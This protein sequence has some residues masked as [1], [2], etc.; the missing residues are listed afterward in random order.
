MYG[1]GKVLMLNIDSTWR[2]RYE[3]GDVYH[4]R[5][6]GNILRWLI[7]TPLEGEGKYVR[8]STDKEQYRQGEVV[9]VTARVL[10]KGYYPF[11]AGPVFVEVTDP[12]ASVR[13]VPLELQDPKTGLYEGRLTAASSGSWRLQSVVPDL[14]E[15]G[16]L[17]AVKI[18]VTAEKLED[19]SLRMRAALLRDLAAITGGR[20]HML[21]TADAI[22]DEIKRLHATSS[23]TDRKG[24]WDTL[25]VILL[26]AAFI[27]V[28]WLLRKRKGY[29]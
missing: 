1:T 22:P 24:L 9:T 20:F 25:Y 8:L 18:E 14:G 10:D 19:R 26:F 2:W 5:F 27:T 11:S 6:W 13:R 12:F 7:A 15:E 21:D 29:V 28:E 3:H 17:A 23:V 4:Y 16:T